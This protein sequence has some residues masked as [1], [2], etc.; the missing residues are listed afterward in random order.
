MEISVNTQSLLFEGMHPNQEVL[1]THGDSITSI[2]S[3]LKQIAHSG[4]LVAGIEHNEKKLYGLQFHPEVRPNLN[5]FVTYDDQVDLTPNGKKIFQNFLFNIAGLSGSF[6]LEDREK[7]SIEY[8]RNRYGRNGKCADVAQST[9]Q[10]GVGTDQRRCRFH[11][12][13][14]SPI[15]SNVT[16]KSICTPY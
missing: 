6:T 9:R 15:E 4:H 3:D 13:W 10:E 8:I 2:G 1:L 7:S 14:G 5:Q 12:L 16:R 11:S